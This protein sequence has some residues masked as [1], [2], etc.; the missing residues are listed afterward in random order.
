MKHFAISYGEDPYSIQDAI[1][2]QR[3][4]GMP[5]YQTEE[6]A[7]LAVEAANMG[8]DLALSEMRAAFVG[9][10]SEIDK[11]IASNR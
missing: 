9:V 8:Y 4:P 5:D 7:A 11:Q 3:I 2:R 1:T 6:I 10:I